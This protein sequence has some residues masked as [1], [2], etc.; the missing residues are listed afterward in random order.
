MTA[1]TAENTATKQ[2][3][4]QDTVIAEFKPLKVQVLS[5]TSKYQ[6]QVF[7]VTTG[8]GIS[9]ARAARAEIRDLR[10]AIQKTIKAMLP[11]YQQAVKDA[12]AKVNEVKAYGQGFIE[13]VMAV[14]E[15]ID[16]QIKA[17]EQR[18]A[19]IKAEKARKEQE[20]IDKIQS[21][22]Q[23]FR[24]ASTM[25]AGKSAAEIESLLDRVGN[26]EVEDDVYQEFTDDAIAAK[27]DAIEA[28][29]KM[30]DERRTF[31]AEQAKVAAERA[32][33]EALREA[34]AKADEERRLED[35]KREAARQAEVE[36]QRKQEAKA[37]EERRI[38][39]QRRKDAEFFGQVKSKASQA[40]SRASGI[41][42][43]QAGAVFDA[44]NLGDIP[45]IV[46]DL[47]A[48]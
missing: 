19:D 1:N 2:S 44:I 39:E 25:T 34:Q 17:E 47:N 26:A 22:I 38:E 31:E 16:E 30:L 41:S 7:D 48:A 18:K 3:N 37:E 23:S 24:N 45:F 6:G 9:D 15:P 33:L 27:D 20:R 11:T 13:Q 8:N 43:E 14:E 5:I 46:I 35:A 36:L 29:A 10:Y 12:Q 32:E 42:A 4:E 21:K 28:L 40:I